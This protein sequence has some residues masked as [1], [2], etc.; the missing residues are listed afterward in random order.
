MIDNLLFWRE[1]APR[2]VV[3][4]AKAEQQRLQENA[5]LGNEPTAGKTPV[6]ERKRKGL[7]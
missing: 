3:V 7:F 5:A 2:G 1:K 6:I 4:D